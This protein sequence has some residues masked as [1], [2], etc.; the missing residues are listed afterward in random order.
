MVTIFIF[1]ITLFCSVSSTEAAFYSERQISTLDSLQNNIAQELSVELFGTLHFLENPTSQKQEWLLL[2]LTYITLERGGDA[3]RYYTYWQDH[4]QLKEHAFWLENAERIPREYLMSMLKEKISQYPFSFF[5]QVNDYLF[6]DIVPKATCIRK[7]LFPYK[8]SISY[9]VLQ[10]T[11]EGL[12]IKVLS[13]FCEKLERDLLQLLEPAI[14]ANFTEKK[15]V[16]ILLVAT[17]IA[18]KDEKDIYIYTLLWNKFDCLQGHVKYLQSSNSDS[19]RM[20]KQMM[21]E[22]KPTVLKSVENCLLHDTSFSDLQEN[23]LLPALKFYIIKYG[24]VI[25]NEVL[26]DLS[27]KIVR[28]FLNKNGTVALIL[29]R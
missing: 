20:V 19:I 18:L 10:E 4:S 7:V 8:K 17:Y 14:L 23:Q 27:V 24:R 1:Y 5:D 29:L 15:R 22:H 6:D 16:W 2:V 9:L 3:S 25:F 13:V 21:Y 26:D 11:V 12:P 28:S